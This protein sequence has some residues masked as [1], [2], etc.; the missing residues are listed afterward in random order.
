MKFT[1][2]LDLG[3]AVDAPLANP[4]GAPGPSPAHVAGH[5]VRSRSA[6]AADRFIGR[7]GPVTNPSP[8]W[9]ATPLIGYAGA[10]RLQDRIE[11]LERMLASTAR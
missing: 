6:R 10:P 3:A 2:C 4:G 11:A 1:W 9:A 8:A 7:P 5:H